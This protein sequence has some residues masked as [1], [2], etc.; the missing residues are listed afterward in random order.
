V[1]VEPCAI[2]PNFGGL[3]SEQEA[4]DAVVRRVVAAVDPQAVWLFGSRARGDARPDG[5]FDLLVVGKADGALTSDDYE[6]VDSAINGTGIGC[7]LVPCSAVDFREGAEL[8]TS[9]IAR[10]LIE[11]RPIYASRTAMVGYERNAL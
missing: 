6:R 1:S 7:D 3:S 4:L 10:I 9:L 11:G 5:D 8:A 2:R